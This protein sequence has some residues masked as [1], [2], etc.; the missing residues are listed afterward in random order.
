MDISAT[1]LAVIFSVIFVIAVFVIL[2]RFKSKPSNEMNGST[3]D[4]NEPELTSVSS[5]DKKN[6]M[7]K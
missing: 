1:D 2:S 5:K 4:I 6:E 3:K 7:K